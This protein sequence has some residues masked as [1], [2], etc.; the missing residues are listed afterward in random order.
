MQQAKLFHDGMHSS[1]T[2]SK[3]VNGHVKLT[4]T[5]FIYFPH[6]SQIVELFL[7]WRFFSYS[8]V[9]AADPILSE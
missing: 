6:I 2:I 5:L 7:L 9:E 3:D 8:F 1:H 4:P